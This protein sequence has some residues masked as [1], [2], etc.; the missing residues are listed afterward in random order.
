[1]KNLYKIFFILLVILTIACKKEAFKQ[2][3]RTF[4]MAVTPW[5]P[6][7]TRFGKEKAYDFINNQCDMI[8]NHFD[9]GIPWE[10]ALNGTSY[11]SEILDNINERLDNNN[12]RIV[13]LALAPLSHS[14]KNIAEYW[15]KNTP[16][17]IKAKWKNFSLDD[18]LVANAYFNFCC[19]LID[20]FHPKYFNYAVEANNKDW[21]ESEFSK[22]LTFLGNVY[23]RLK[24]KYPDQPVF[25]S[26]MVSIDQKQLENAKRINPYSDYIS[27]S[28][29]PYMEISSYSYGS[30]EPINIPDNWYS[31]YRNIDVNKPFA[32]AETG[33][34]AEDLDLSEYGITKKGD[35]KWQ[36]DFLQG[37][38]KM[39]NENNAVFVSYFCAYD[40]DN[41]WNT[42]QAIGVALP[43]FKMWKDIGLYDGQG[44][45]RPSLQVW[46]KWYNAKKIN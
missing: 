18:T 40:Y 34:I 6:D 20:T 45:E 41:A 35:P 14:R 36:A 10:E 7:F 2:E 24:N 38:F 31:K 43:Y 23:P 9:D 37:F 46:K 17:S 13:Y 26:Y 3:N 27:L 21:E 29:Y 32:I 1:M 42:M 33:Y 30:T 11:P 12:G 5:P 16:D 28:S 25:A 15:G 19:F 8:C 44:I 22:F 39:C 4:Y